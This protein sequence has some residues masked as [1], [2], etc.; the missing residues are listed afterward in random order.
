ME[1]RL[2]H[3]VISFPSGNKPS[4]ITQ[5]GNGSFDLPAAF[6][7]AERSSVPTPGSFAVGSMRSNEFNQLF[8]EFITKCVRVV[9]FVADQMLGFSCDCRKLLVRKFYLMREAE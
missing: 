3:F 6:V 9:S 2:I 7:T 5:P 4:V 1:K 8:F